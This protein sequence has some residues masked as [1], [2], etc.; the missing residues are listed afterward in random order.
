MSEEMI[1]A[2]ERT[3]T[4]IIEEIDI[5]KA[6]VEKLEKIGASRNTPGECNK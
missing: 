5:L 4:W 2:I 3:L 6:K 1:D